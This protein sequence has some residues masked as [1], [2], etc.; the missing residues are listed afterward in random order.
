MLISEI[1]FIGDNSKELLIDFLHIN[2]KWIKKIIKDALIKGEVDKNI[3][4]D[5][6]A[7]SYISLLEGVLLKFRISK[8]YIAAKNVIEKNLQLFFAVG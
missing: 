8:D 2:E 4:I 7:D 5:F 6:F 3:D 1:N